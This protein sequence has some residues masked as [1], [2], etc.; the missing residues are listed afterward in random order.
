MPFAWVGTQMR[1]KSGRF[2]VFYQS[3]EAG[4][5]FGKGGAAANDAHVSSESC[6]DLQKKAVTVRA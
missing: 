4:T 1:G 2:N 6:I 5:V 3:L